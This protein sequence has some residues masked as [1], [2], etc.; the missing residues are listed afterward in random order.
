MLLH[1]GY[2]PCESIIYNSS[3]SL[4]IIVYVPSQQQTQHSA[5]IGNYTMDKDNIK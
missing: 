5:V 2:D 3:N 1:P 4:F